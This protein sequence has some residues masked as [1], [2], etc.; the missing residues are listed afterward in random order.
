MGP[1][2]IGLDVIINTAESWGDIQTIS[3]KKFHPS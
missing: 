3:G 2:V 1:E